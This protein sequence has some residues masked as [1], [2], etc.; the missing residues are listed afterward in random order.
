MPD[1]YLHIQIKYD[2][3]D[4][5]R[6]ELDLIELGQSLQGA[7]R[8]IRSAALVSIIN[9]KIIPA[10][11]RLR[12]LAKPPAPG[13]YI[14]DTVIAPLMPI[15][16]SLTVGAN[17]AIEALVNLAI[18]KFTRKPNVTEQA[19]K[20]AELA[21]SEMGLTARASIDGIARVCEQRQAVRQF[22]A[23]IG[24]SCETA[25]I[26]ETPAVALLFDRSDRE[27]I[28]EPEKTEIGVEDSYEILISELDLENR[29]CKF[30]IR[31]EGKE[32]RFSGTIT[33]PSIKTIRNNYS[34]SM[35]EHNWL[36]VRAKP[37][38]SESEVVHLYISDSTI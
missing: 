32:K 24:D 6:K 8:I 7:G 28:E 29:S 19:L 11:V 30:L 27:E 36:K 35:S 5:A 31:G 4:A 15:L 23:P 26:G 9:P 2:G 12:V 16:P 3:L 14:I 37:E 21:L 38:T 1:D 17:K 22:V 20:V 18:S 25:Q 13:S 34:I 33:D 10:S